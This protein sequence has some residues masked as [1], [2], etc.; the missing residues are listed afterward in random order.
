MIMY[1]LEEWAQAKYALG[2]KVTAMKIIQEAHQVATQAGERLS[3]VHTI[4]AVEADFHLHAGNIPAVTR[5]AE[6]VG[7]ASKRDPARKRQYAL[8]IRLLLAQKNLEEACGLLAQFERSARDDQRYRQLIT[9]YIQH[10]LAYQMLGQEEDSVSYMDQALRL[11]SPENY[12]RAF[13]EEGPMVADL[14]PKARPSAPT[15]VDALLEV[16]TGRSELAGRPLNDPLSQREIEVLR[17][18]TQNLTSPQ[19]AET[20]VVAVS[21]VRSHVKHIYR[22][23]GAHSRYE[24]IERAKTLGLL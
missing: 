2:E 24:A 21:T 16:F 9:F 1:A 14:L 6:S 4:A 18:M 13:I 15:F 19:M 11:A 23:L 10:A 5:W 8:Y 3:W 17:L 20:L 22:K 12:A 7:F